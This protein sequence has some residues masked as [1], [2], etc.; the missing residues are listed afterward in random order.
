MMV[1]RL[2]ISIASPLLR[3]CWLATWLLFL[4]GTACSSGQTPGIPT[5]FSE[6]VQDKFELYIDLPK[7]YTR[8]QSYSVVYYMDANL[9]MGQELRR[10]IKLA[11]NQSNLSQVI[12]VGIG[13]IGNY[14]K[15]RRRDFIPPKMEAGEWVESTDPDFG[16]GDAFY[17]FLTEELM[18][19]IDNEYATNGRNSFIGHSFS[20]LF[21]FYCLLQPK[22]IFTNHIALS[23]SLWVNYHNFF[24]VEKAFSKI[25]KERNTYLY[26]ACGSGEWANKVRSSSRDM[27]QV[28]EERD[29]TGL[30]YKYVEHP[31]KGHNGVVAVAL[32]QVLKNTDF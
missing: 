3:H 11:K 6:Q 14:R 16:H 22:L 27:R 13:H 32:D 2:G 4:V 30:Q 8:D 19:K 21:A 23:P 17:R 15:L 9:K 12:F 25:D 31:G 24:E 5:I 28:L 29:Y 18:P 20:G 1:Q 7:D 26:H 10:Q